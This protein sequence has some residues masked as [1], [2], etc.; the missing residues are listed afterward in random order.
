MINSF[1]N[2]I[3]FRWLAIIVFITIPIYYLL[4]SKIGNWVYLIMTVQ[5]VIGVIVGKLYKC[6]NCGKSFDLR[7]SPNE[8]KHCPNCSADLNQH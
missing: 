2:A 1:K 3:R 5:F 4:K 8:L 6:P 7:V